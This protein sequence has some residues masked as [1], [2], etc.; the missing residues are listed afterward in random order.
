MMTEAHMDGMG[1]MMG[2]MGLLFV[3]VVVF[4][5]AGIVFFVRNTGS[6]RDGVRMGSVDTGTTLIKGNRK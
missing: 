1:W 4:L 5:I 2:G 6:R 3:L